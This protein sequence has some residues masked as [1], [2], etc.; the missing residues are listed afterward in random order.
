MSDTAVGIALAFG[1]AAFFFLR[2]FIRGARQ[3]DLMGEV[4][5]LVRRRRGRPG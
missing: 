1:L 5:A 3:N 2:G 4:R